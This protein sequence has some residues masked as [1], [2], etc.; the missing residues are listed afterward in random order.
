MTCCDLWTV[1]NVVKK[2]QFG[3][4]SAHKLLELGL[5]KGRAL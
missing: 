1:I 4:V 2:P 5:G 3:S